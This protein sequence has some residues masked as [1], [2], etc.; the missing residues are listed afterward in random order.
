MLKDRTTRHAIAQAMQAHGCGF[1][2]SL[3]AALLA[4]DQADALRLLAAFP[5]L[6]QAYGPGT[7]AFTFWR[8]Q[9]AAA[10]ALAPWRAGARAR[11]RRAA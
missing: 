8:D 9:L 6:V 10:G 11:L 2:A 3:G 4:A 7:D 5:E 1:V